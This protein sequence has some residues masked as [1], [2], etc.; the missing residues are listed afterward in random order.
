MAERTCEDCGQRMLP[1]VPRK[2]RDDGSKVCWACAMS[3]R[4]GLVNNKEAAKGD[5]TD[6]WHPGDLFRHMQEDHRMHEAEIPTHLSMMQWT[7]AQAHEPDGVQ[8]K[9]GLVGWNSQHVHAPSPLVTPEQLKVEH[10]FHP[11]GKLASQGIQEP[12][13]SVSLFSEERPVA[14]LAWNANTDEIQDLWVSG[15]LRRQGLASYMYEYAKSLGFHPVHS[16]TRSTAGDA[17]GK[18]VGIEMPEWTGLSPRE[19][20]WIDDNLQ[21]LSGDMRNPWDDPKTHLLN[22]HGYHPDTVNYFENKGPHALMAFHES[23]HREQ[24]RVQNRGEEY[25]P[26]VL[27]PHKHNPLL[28]STSVRK[29]A[30]DSGDGETIYHCPFCGSGQ[31]IARSDKTVECEFCHT[32]FTVQVQ[33]EMSAFPQTINGLPVDVPGMPGEIGSEGG[34]DPMDPSAIPGDETDAPGDGGGDSSDSPLTDNKDSDSDSD[35]SNPFSKSSFRTESGYQL[36]LDW[37]LRHL[38]YQA[39]RPLSPEDL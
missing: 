5:P 1:Y 24:N 39:N 6:L 38:A 4:G 29:I 13:H 34:D 20:S 19:A 12:M 21:D 36:D 30:H 15:H 25:R 31:V 10:N 16:Q 32:A 14:H 9:D 23:E 8:T 35:D 37:Y 33:P 27:K 11:A 2:T 7:H 3:P 18:A 22:E 26:G 17:W 28:P